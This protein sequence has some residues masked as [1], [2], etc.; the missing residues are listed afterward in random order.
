MESLFLSVLRFDM[1]VATFELV[2]E[3]IDVPFDWWNAS[4]WIVDCVLCIVQFGA[5]AY[6]KIYK[7]DERWQLAG[8]GH[9]ILLAKLGFYPA[10]ARQNGGL[11][12][13]AALEL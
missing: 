12:L 11:C 3:P 8:R 1:Q 4:Y 10:A 13:L 6:F 5:P 9:P 7:F 2:R